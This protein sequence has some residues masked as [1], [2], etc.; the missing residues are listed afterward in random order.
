MPD[1]V[2][3][4]VA[5]GHS[6][7]ATT[8]GLLASL[9][10][11]PVR[12][13]EAARVTDDDE[14]CGRIVSADALRDFDSQRA[15]QALRRWSAKPLLLLGLG[16]GDRLAPALAAT[17]G[18]T[19]G[20]AAWT[21]RDYLLDAELSP[22]DGSRREAADRSLRVL[23][24]APGIAGLIGCSGGIVFGRLGAGNVHVATAAGWEGGVPPLLRSA[25]RP[26]RFLDALPIIAFSR[27][28][29]GEAGWE[30]RR[31][32][33]TVIVDD[34]N[35][36]ALRYGHLDFR[37]ALELAESH[38]FHLAMGF[39]PL[40]Y[41]RTSARVADLFRANSDRLS[42]VVHGNDH[43]KRELARPVAPP[44][45]RFSA[46]QALVRMARHEELTQLHC[47][48]VMTMPHGDSNVVWL[49]ALRD[50]GY[51]AALSGRSYAFTDHPELSGAGPLFEMLPSENSL[52]GFPIINRWSS[53]LPLDDLWFGAYLRKPV[54]MYTHHQFF[55]DW[56]RFLDAVAAINS[57][58][59][60]EW[61]GVERLVEGNYQ[62]RRTDVDGAVAVNAHSNRIRVSLPED[63]RSVTIS[64]AG[65]AIPADGE[66]VEVEGAQPART[67]RSAEAISC[68]VDPAGAT[69]LEVR[70]NP[71][72]LPSKPRGWERTAVRSRVRR[73]LT[74][75]RDRLAPVLG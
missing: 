35:L 52:F 38:D 32:R 34:P 9:A 1:R 11:V 51:A 6:P 37:R 27:F 58:V 66:T 15:G 56:T 62:L 39:V 36:R 19:V 22:L 18:V 60:P 10:G 71:V 59:A 41:Q 53:E 48:P 13:T 46:T 40:D 74:E 31:L 55:A 65:R 14:V 43:L 21:G 44:V 64:K 12:S 47:P 26:A 42:L 17:T 28:A 16:D 61:C 57:R 75:T 33:A 23:R 2:I 50:A 4:L 25:F 7:L 29:A 8:V 63:A 68:T 54:C 67:S 5:E 70:F 49:R 73:M 20:T 3:E 45:A 72:S 24:P 30:Q 69:E